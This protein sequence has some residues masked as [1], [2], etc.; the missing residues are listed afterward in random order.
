MLYQLP[1]NSLYGD[2]PIPICFPDNW[3]VHISEFAGYSCSAMDEAE[4][5][6]GVHAAIGAAPISQGA[7]GRK[8]AVIIIDDITLAS[9]TPFGPCVHYLYDRWGHSSP[10][11]LMWSGCYSKEAKMGKAIVFA[12]HTI[13][14]ARDPWYIDE[15]SGAI[16]LRDWA[17]VLAELDDGTAKKAVIYPNAEC[18]IVIPE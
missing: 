1:S 8:S 11:G 5:R 2:K 13:K 4:L 14:G 6:R 7:R 12:E 3:D 17:R 16:Y 10:G 18:Q 9:N 15:R